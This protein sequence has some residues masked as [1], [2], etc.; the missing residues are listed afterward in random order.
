MDRAIEKSR[1]SAKAITAIGTVIVCTALVVALLV[2]SRPS[3]MTIDPTRITLSRV[4]DGQ[5]IE[6]IPILGT[7]EPIKTVFLDAVEGGQV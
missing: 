1:W 5:F 2:D 4:T 6:Y 3:T 7:V